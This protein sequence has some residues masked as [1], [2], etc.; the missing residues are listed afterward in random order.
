[1]SQ[2]T[3]YKALEFLLALLLKSTKVLDIYNDIFDIWEVQ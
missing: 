2:A 3:S 1:M